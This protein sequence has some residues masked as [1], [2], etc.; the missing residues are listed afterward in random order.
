MHRE[1]GPPAGPWLWEFADGAALL[2]GTAN[3]IMQLARPEVGYG[4]V[5][6]R[7]P[8]AQLMRHPL[9]RGWSTV[10][11]LSVSLFGTAAERAAFRRLVNRSHAQV[12][13]TP[14]SPVSYRAS[15]PRLQLWVAACLYR[16]MDDMHTLLH[17]PAGER[18][19]DMV[20]RHA[21]RLGTSLQM[22]VRLWP[23]DRAAFARYWDA[24]LRELRIDP[25]V[26]AYLDELI[27]LRYLPRPLGAA[28]GPLNRFVT[29]GL[30]PPPLRELMRLPWTARDQRRFAALMRAIAAVD[31]LLPGPVRRFPFN[32]LLYGWR[33]RMR[34]GAGPGRAAAS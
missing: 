2:A 33:A 26:R 13:S 20:Y 14:L 15:D 3:V 19:A 10:T 27:M 9:R 34:R 25:P 16:G 21:S 18:T 11:Y 12:R 5:E 30:L 32:A 24:A 7:V 29:T 4:V 6:S 23:P 17:G 31:R 8:G 1:A 28:L 22:P